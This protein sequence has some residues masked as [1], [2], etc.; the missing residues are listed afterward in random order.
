MVGAVVVVVLGGAV[1]VAGLL[2]ALGRLP[3]NRLVGVRTPATLRSDEAFLIGNRVAAPAIVL[4]GVAAMAGGIA[5]LFLSK[6]A[7]DGAVLAGV[8]AM[9]VLAIVGGIQG[10]RAAGR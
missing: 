8:L 4:G 10:S 3:R 7:A 9:G 6:A 5:G 2:G 1:V